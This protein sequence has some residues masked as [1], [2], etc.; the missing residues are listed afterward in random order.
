[1]S[2]NRSRL[3]QLRGEVFLTDGGIET[4][5]IFDDGFESGELSAWQVG[6]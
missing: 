2:D 5:L 6:G 1:M 3:P 4:S